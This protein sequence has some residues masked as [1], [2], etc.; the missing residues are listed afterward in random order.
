MAD[1]LKTPTRDMLVPAIADDPTLVAMSAAL[2]DMYAKAKAS[3]D[4]LLAVHDIRN[5]E[6]TDIVDVLAWGR[7]VDFYNPAPDADFWPVE[8]RR[9][10]VAR[11]L[12]WHMLKGTPFAVKDLVA[13][14]F[15]DAVVE[16]WFEYGGKP[17][18]FRAGTE[19]THVDGA[20]I[21]RLIDAIYSI[22][23]ER[24]WLEGIDILRRLR[25]EIFVG[26]G[27]LHAITTRIGLDPTSSLWY[28]VNRV[29]GNADVFGIA[30]ETDDGIYTIEFNGT[31]ATMDDDVLVLI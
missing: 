3:V 10:I 2:D 12:E 21:Q 16:E 19:M 29:L 30:F 8:I 9:D 18:F 4:S 25:G 15:A 31:M 28:V 6:D 23:N 17:Y 24:S 14:V 20:T 1:L 22:K 7:H 13:T 11:S 27:M 5:I 26:I